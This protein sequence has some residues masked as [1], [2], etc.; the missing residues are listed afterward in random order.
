MLLREPLRPTVFDFEA[1]AISTV[2]TFIRD[3]EKANDYYVA[4][5][6]EY[7]FV[8]KAVVGYPDLPAI[9]VL[10]SIATTLVNDL[11]QYCIDAA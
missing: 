7:F 1:L 9:P 5:G 4:K 11:R 6:F 8:T 3:L 2:V 10:E